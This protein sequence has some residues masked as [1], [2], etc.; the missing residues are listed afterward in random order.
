MCK[1]INLFGEPGCG[2]SSLAAYIFYRLKVLGYNCELV[3][4]FA[5]DKVYENS[6]NELENQSYI[7]GMQL[8]RMNRLKDNVDIIITD[9]PLLLCGLYMRDQKLYNN[10][11]NLVYDSFNSWDNYNYLLECNHP[12]VTSGRLQD[13]N[14]ANQIRKDLITSLDY[15]K[16]P[17]KQLVSTMD[18]NN[19]F[20]NAGEKIITDII[21]PCY[22]Y[23][24]FIPVFS[25]SVKSYSLHNIFNSI[26]NWCHR[27]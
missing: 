14:G 20:N 18:K 7:F 6:M 2:K 8:Q 27:F 1:V 13:E 4:E 12:Y 17:Y 21:D 25:K 23:Q 3:T 9:S 22:R 26:K 19:A 11:F 15:Y 16:V 5:K 24:E 10:F